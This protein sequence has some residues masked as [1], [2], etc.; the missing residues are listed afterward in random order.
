MLLHRWVLSE[1]LVAE[2]G[3]NGDLVTTLGAAAVEDGSAGLGGH[4]NEEA[5]NLRAA[6]AIGLEGALGHRSVPV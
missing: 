2:T 4:A 5:M 1:Q 3:R 6:T